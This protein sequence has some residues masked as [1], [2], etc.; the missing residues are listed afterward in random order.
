MGNEVATLLRGI[1]VEYVCELKRQGLT[2][3][4]ISELSGF[5]PKTIRKY[6]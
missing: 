3:C 2:I 6:V 1:N 4:Q 5:D